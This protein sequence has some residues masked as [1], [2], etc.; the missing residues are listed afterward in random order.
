MA[1][2]L[3]QTALGL[4][5][6]AQQKDYLIKLIARRSDDVIG[7][8]NDFVQAAGGSLKSAALILEE[9]V[10]GIGEFTGGDIILDVAE[11]AYGMWDTASGLSKQLCRA[12]G[13]EWYSGIGSR[14]TLNLRS[15][16]ASHQIGDSVAQ[17]NQELAASCRQVSSLLKG[18][19]FGKMRRPWALSFQEYNLCEYAGFLSRSKAVRPE[20]KSLKASPQRGGGGAFISS[21]H[22][23]D[24][25]PSPKRFKFHEAA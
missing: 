20:C 5:Q 17:W 8:A 10:Y 23:A 12:S 2:R 3:R 7:A 15:A 9:R 1:V 14:T 4:K 25:A 18:L 11:P 19:R 22:S 16:R 6:V 24:F 13:H 21:G